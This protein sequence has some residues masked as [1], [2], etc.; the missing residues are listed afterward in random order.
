MFIGPL[1]TIVVLT[2]FLMKKFLFV[3]FSKKYS[4]YKVQ[5]FQKCLF[6][7]YLQLLYWL[8]ADFLVWLP[9]LTHF[10]PTHLLSNSLTLQLTNLLRG[11]IHKVQ[12]NPGRGSW[13]TRHLFCYFLRNSIFK[14]GQ[15]GEWGRVQK[16]DF[17]RTSFLNGP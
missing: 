7:H 4:S 9:S 14:P 11:L 15:T 16:P 17:H 1:S 10:C 5:T 8:Y 3:Y 13:K 12:H 6:D 2:V